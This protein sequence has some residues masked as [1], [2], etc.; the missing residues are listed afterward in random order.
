MVAG[1][2]DGYAELNVDYIDAYNALWT[3][4]QGVENVGAFDTK[5]FSRLPGITVIGPEEAR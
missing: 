1:A 3:T 5:H 4:M 2:L